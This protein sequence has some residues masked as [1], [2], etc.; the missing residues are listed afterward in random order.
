VD[1][2]YKLGVWLQLKDGLT[3]GLDSINK[4]GEKVFGR[5]KDIRMAVLGVGAAFTIMGFAALGVGNR[6]ADKFGEFE[7]IMALTRGAIGANAQEFKAMEKAALAAGIAT[8]F[9]PTEA[10]AGMRDIGLAGFRPDDITKLLLPSLDLAAASGGL[11]SVAESAGMVVKAIKS[12]GTAVED[13]GLAT[14]QIIKMSNSF[15]VSAGELPLLFATAARG[16]HSLSQ[17]LS[18][19]AIAL[20]FVKNT[21]LRTETAATA[22]AVSME[23]M[24]SSRVQ[25]KLMKLGKG[26]AVDTNGV[27]R[28]YLDIV[29]DIR[30]AMEG[31]SD[32]AAKNKLQYIFGRYGG[33]AINAIIKQINQGITTSTGEILKG[34]DA[35]N[36]YR[37][38][39]ANAEGTAKKMAKILLDTWS[40]QKI[41]LQGSVETLQIV[42]GRTFAEIFRPAIEATI[43][44]VNALIYAWEGLSPQARQFLVLIPLIG[45]ALGGLVVGIFAAKVAWLALNAVFVATPLGWIALAMGAIAV[46]VAG[47]IVYW[48]KLGEVIKRSWALLHDM[49]PALFSA[50]DW[51]GEVAQKIPGMF[52]TA[53]TGIKEIFTRAIKWIVSL[54]ESTPLGKSLL[55]ALGVP[56][57]ALFDAA[58]KLWDKNVAHDK[59]L[60]SKH[61]GDFSWSDPEKPGEEGAPKPSF[62]QR[63]MATIAGK[64]ADATGAGGGAA[65]GG[66]TGGGEHYDTKIEFNGTLIV[67]AADL[68]EARKASDI[69]VAEL[70]GAA[71]A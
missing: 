41:L 32:A 48:D 12:Y 40:G 56:N 64:G 61:F 33:G 13:A 53:V 17:S 27:F 6:L 60:L 34:A 1:S 11:M 54:I 36:Y 19:T 71:H 31:M 35:I 8:Q 29:L 4:L 18:E 26:I 51:L 21:G 23:R 3:H 69:L 62:L 70:L 20:G 28:P 45:G 10:A 66:G 39:L 43:V 58:G 22:V 24:V 2:I 67:Q 44:A 65:G 16:A 25:N 14:D 50:V 46:A 47:V 5:F 9:S 42:L 63:T 7:K 59:A 68:F 30:S 15:Y 49:F 52:S 37:H 55:K 38:E 57:A